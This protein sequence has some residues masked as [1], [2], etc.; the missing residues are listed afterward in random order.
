MIG[1]SRE[2]VTRLLSEFKR[3][4]VIANGGG[5]ILVRNRKALALLACC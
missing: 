4:H 3:K 1:A 5:A 2:T